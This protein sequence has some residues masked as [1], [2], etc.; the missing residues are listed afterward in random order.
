MNKEENPQ[1]CNQDGCKCNNNVSFVINQPPVNF[2]EFC[3]TRSED[4]REW[5]EEI[6]EL[7]KLHN[8]PENVFFSTR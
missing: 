3:G 7:I 8:W 4:V 5:I 6:E 2:P 1:N